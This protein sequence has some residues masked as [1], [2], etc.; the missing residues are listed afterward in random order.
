[1]DFLALAMLLVKI[2]GMGE[3]R[4]EMR[5]KNWRSSTSL[6]SRIC[7]SKRP[8]QNSASHAPRFTDG[9][10]L[11]KL[12]GWKLWQINRPGHHGSGTT[13]S[14]HNYE[15]NANLTVTGLTLP[16]LTDQWHSGNNPE[17][18]FCSIPK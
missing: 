6:N 13:T 16:D 18:N 11:T 7:R 1:M 9:L 2:S 17:E 12:A 14:L 3:A 15:R 4:N 10:T 5:S 8:W